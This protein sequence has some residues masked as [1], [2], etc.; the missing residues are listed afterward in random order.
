MLS[1]KHS[2]LLTALTPLFVCQEW[3]AACNNAT[4]ANRPTHCI[5][6]RR[7]DSGCIELAAWF[8]AKV[9]IPSL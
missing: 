3:Q 5:Y 1:P 7:Y 4:P 2:L 6:L 9:I 8:C